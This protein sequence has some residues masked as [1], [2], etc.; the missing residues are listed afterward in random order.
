MRRL[1]AHFKDRWFDVDHEHNKFY[2]KYDNPQDPSMEVFPAYFDD[3][4]GKGFLNPDGSFNEEQRAEVEAQW[5]A[6]INAL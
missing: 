2:V 5:I 1:K 3:D 6:K 4:E